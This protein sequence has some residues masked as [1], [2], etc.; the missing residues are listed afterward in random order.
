MWL[1]SGT[2][3]NLVIQVVILEVEMDVKLGKENEE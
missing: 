3:M 2:W 1:L